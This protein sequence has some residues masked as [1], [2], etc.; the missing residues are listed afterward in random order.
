MLKERLAAAN[1]IATDLAEVEA[2]VDLVISKMGNLVTS[3]PAGQAAVNLSPVAGDA[4]Y[5][6]IEGAFGSIL[7]GRSKLVAF[8]HE[9]E[10][11]KNNVGLKNFRVTG[12][13]DAVKI[14]EPQGR[15]D[16]NVAAETRAA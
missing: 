3:L 11:I 7:A 12:T 10:R 16:D 1:K 5:G 6:H 14:L 13:G 2:A 15:N 8:H 9:M 4:A